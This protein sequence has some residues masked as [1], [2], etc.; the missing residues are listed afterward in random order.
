MRKCNM[1]KALND[2][3][4]IVDSINKMHE[5]GE[6]KKYISNIYFP[7]YKNFEE[8]SRID[9]NFPLTVIVGKNGS[10]KSS[11]LHALYGCPKGKSLGD[12]WFSTATDPI[13]EVNKD[14]KRNC[15]IYTY[16]D[17][18]ELNKQVLK[19]RASRPGTKT[20][21][22]NPD[23]WETSRPLE[24]Y[25]MSSQKRFAPIDENVIYLDFRE[26]MSAFDKFFYFGNLKGLKSS[27]KQDF[28]RETSPKLEKVFKDKN[29][30]YHTSKG[31]DQNEKFE[32]LTSYE[33]EVASE[34]LG[35][36]YVSGKIVRHHFYRNWGYSALVKKGDNSYTEAHAGSGEYAIIKLIHTLGK[37]KEPTLILLD[38]PETSLY[39]GAQKRLLQYLL[40][41]V[42]K[43]KSQMII[44][45]HSEKF[46]SQLPQTAI[47]AIHCDQKTGNSTILQNCSPNTVFEEL[48]LPVK[49]RVQVVVEDRAAKKVIDAV[50]AK[51]NI[52]NISVNF[53]G[54]G[55][56]TLKKYSIWQDATF[57]VKNK[58]YV[59]DGDQKIDIID[60][61]KL[62]RDQYT[63]LNFID[64]QVEKIASKI[65]FPSSKTRRKE[66]KVI[67][68]KNK[69]NAELKYLRFFKKYVN[70]LPSSTPE[71]MIFD[72]ELA[73]TLL[74]S[75][76]LEDI[77]W[78]K[79]TSK[80]KIYDVAKK[81]K[82]A[83]DSPSYYSI[84]NFFVQKWVNNKG[85][86]YNE[87]KKYLTRIANA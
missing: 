85:K 45:T 11:I 23:Y 71:D 66:N 12:F 47:K 69:Y 30:I 50:I 70:F 29:K 39:P 5:N 40:T 10:G 56:D 63:D 83:E 49:N 34:I 58:Y 15:F 51:E 53:I 7:Y 68:D 67:K 20:K 18:T 26:E 33:L 28:I 55:A 54:C 2:S 27:K 14:G 31:T 86:G 3:K 65:P 57:G 43:T 81:L 62:S 13:K 60:V 16:N 48:D 84:F 41:I 37:I 36:K 8:F 59:L 61:D 72:R 73:N 78:D 19:T 21:K 38:E 82:N 4:E 6:F 46:I 25:K 76:G 44:S 77:N 42:K 79:A 24:K 52:K 9:F 22:I 1:S 74:N 75:V 64:K 87:I 80:Q 17:E 32:E 35:T